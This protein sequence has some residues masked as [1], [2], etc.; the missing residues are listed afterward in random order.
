MTEDEERRALASVELVKGKYRIQFLQ[1][2]P[3]PGFPDNVQIRRA[4]RN[5]PWQVMHVTDAMEYVRRLRRRQMELRKIAAN[6]KRT[7]KLRRALGNIK[8]R[9]AKVQGR[10]KAW[11]AMYEYKHGRPH[12]LKDSDWD[13]RLPSRTP[14]PN[15]KD[16]N[17][18]V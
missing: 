8:D 10:E 1:V 5:Q 11:S 3:A 17:E 12:P 9:F 16:P 7:E 18:N 14:A 2:L 6:K 15:P 13:K 4:G